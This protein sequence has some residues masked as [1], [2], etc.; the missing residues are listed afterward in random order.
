MFET[1]GQPQV[2]VSAPECIYDLSDHLANSPGKL[3]LRNGDGKI[4]IEG[5]GFLWRQAESFLTISNDVKTLIASI[6][7]AATSLNAT[8]QTN[9]V[10]TTNSVHG[11][12]LITSRAGN[13]DMNARH[14]IY[15]GDVRVTDPQMKL[16]CEWLIAD[17]PQ[18][19]QINHIVAETNVVI[20]FTDQK[21][22]ATHAT[23]EKAVY[24]FNVQNGTTNE[25]VTLTGNPQVES[26]QGSSTLTNIADVII[27]N[28]LNNSFR[29]INPHTTIQN[30]NGLIA[31]KTNSPPASTNQLIKP[32]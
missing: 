30:F 12:T 3:F 29:S 6:V 2:V 19:G 1:N 20:D 13:F 5:E 23:G 18:S 9:S 25:T 28:R 10:A 17:L 14:A 21:G 22:R 24:N 27:W 26:T 4:H 16:T 7:L 8:A 11:P 15:S 32:K 31:P